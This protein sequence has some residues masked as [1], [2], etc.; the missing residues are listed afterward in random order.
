MLNCPPPELPP[1]T[2][3]RLTPGRQLQQRLQAAAV[4]RQVADKLPIHHRADRRR[5]DDPFRRRDHGDGFPHAG[6]SQCHPQGPLVGHVQ[7][8][9]AHFGDL[10][11]RQPGGHRVDPKRQD[12]KAKE[13]LARGC[14]LARQARSLVDNRDARARHNRPGLI[15]H[16][17]TER[18]RPALRRRARGA[19]QPGHQQRRH[20][21]GAMPD[22]CLRTMCSRSH[23]PSSQASR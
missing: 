17:A 5:R 2:G 7:D 15:H 4:E 8:Q 11:P 12:R 3:A 21:G 16:R 23:D 18:G 13:P 20:R 6:N 19:E 14:R 22:Q 9:V 1:T 10:E